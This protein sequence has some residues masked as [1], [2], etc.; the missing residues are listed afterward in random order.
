MFWFFYNSFLHHWDK[1]LTKTKILTNKSILFI[2]PKNSQRIFKKIPQKC[3]RI[4]TE[5]PKKSQKIPQ[6]IRLPKKFLRFWK[7]PIPYIALRGRKPFR[8][9]SCNKWKKSTLPARCFSSNKWKVRPVY[10]SLPVYYWGLRE[11]GPILW[12]KFSEWVLCKP[13]LN[14]PL[15]N[16]L[17]FSR[18]TLGISALHFKNGATTV[19]QCWFV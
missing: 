16:K 8:A 18:R 10:S 19:T 7:Y 9:C 5:F 11:F 12:P 15:I 4:P 2:L 17:F 14:S 6:K 13:V 1:T 3:Q